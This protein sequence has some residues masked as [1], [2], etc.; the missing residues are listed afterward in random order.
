VAAHED[1]AAG[2]HGVRVA[3]A[4]LETEHAGVEA[5]G[6]L[7]IGDVEHDVTELA[8]LERKHRGPPGG[9]SSSPALAAARDGIRPASGWPTRSSEPRRPRARRLCRE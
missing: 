3:I 1:H 5:H 7:K 2:H 9:A 4:D 8:Q 6:G